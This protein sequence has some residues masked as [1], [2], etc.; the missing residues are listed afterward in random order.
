MKESAAFV[1]FYQGGIFMADEKNLARAKQVYQTICKMMDQEKWKCKKDDEKLSI[2]AGAQGEDLPMELVIRVDAERQLVMILSHLPYKIPEDKR[3]DVAV[4]VSAIN[5][6]LVHGAMDFNVTDGN[7]FF[8]MA[9]SFMDSDM[10]AD[11]YRYMMYASC[12]TIDEYNDKL[13]MLSKGIVDISK[14]L[15][16][17]KE[18]K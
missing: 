8:R 10:G 17:L 7:L 16:M 9:S 4:A 18:K 14:F 5:N 12:Q 2:E 11:A 6:L 3:L 13:L 1:K 15:E